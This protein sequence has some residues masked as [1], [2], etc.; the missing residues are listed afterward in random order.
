MTSVPFLIG[1]IKGN[2]IRCNYLRKK[3]LFL[4]FFFAFLKF[5]SDLENLKNMTLQ[6]Y[7]FSKKRTTK[8][9]LRGPFHNQ[10]GKQSKTLPK[11]A[12]QHLYYNW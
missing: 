9:I 8:D 1:R 3:K 2:Q 12:R 7:V 5:R 10:H 6:A 11:S 4:K